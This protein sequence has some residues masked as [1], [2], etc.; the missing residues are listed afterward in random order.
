ML[1]LAQHL[2]ANG[3]ASKL[4]FYSLALRMLYCI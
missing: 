1:K 4:L 3:L 2:L